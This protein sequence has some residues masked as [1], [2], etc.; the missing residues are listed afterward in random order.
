MKK[1]VILFVIVCSIV[2]FVL[3]CDKKRSDTLTQ[4]KLKIGFVYIGEV[5]DAGWTYAHDQGRKELEKIPFVEK[6]TIIENVKGND[7]TV[8]AISQ[9]AESG[10]N[11]IFTTSFDYM[12]PTIEVS[13]KYPDIIF[14]NCS[15]RKTAP[16]V[17][18]YSGKMYQATYLAGIVAGKMTKINKIGI[19]ASYRIPEV[20]RNVNSYARGISAVNSKAKLYVI[21]TDSWNDSQKEINATN[22][23]IDMGCDL[24]LQNTDSYSSQQVAEK[25]GVYS[26]GSN[27]DMS[28][29]APNSHL[30]AAVWN[31]GTLYK[32]IA[33]SVYNNSWTNE[34]IFWG[35]EKGLIELG[36][37]NVI[38]PNEVT[39]LVEEKREEII[40]G[41][42]NPFTGPIKDNKGNLRIK[43]GEVMSDEALLLIDWLTENVIEVISK[44]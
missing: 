29:F 6:T 30:T 5:G 41:K 18:T 43:K 22:T 37:Y 20:K 23:L 12:D 16:N 36:P 9:L 2:F 26:I 35:L 19:V 38:V 32:N 8:R 4:K 31:W 24:I 10:H 21:W 28:S 7:E 1:R 14:M 13:Q 25:R 34:Q 11:L 40:K 17:G 15:G 3:S 33:E 27:N 39:F 44:P 42:L